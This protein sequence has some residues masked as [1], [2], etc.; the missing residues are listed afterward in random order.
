[1]NTEETN[2]AHIGIN[3]DQ[4][5]AKAKASATEI[6]RTI[7]ECIKTAGSNGLPSGHLYAMLMGSMDINTY[8]QCISILKRSGIIAENNFILTFIKDA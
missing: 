1:M 8:T 5:E 3:V 4:I 2:Q 6:L 7:A